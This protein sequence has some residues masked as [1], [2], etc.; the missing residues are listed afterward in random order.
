MYTP[1][2]G[3]TTGTNAYGYEAAVVGGKVTVA[4]DGV[5]NM[6]IPSNGYVLSGHGTSRTWLRTYAKVGATV[7]LDGTTTPLPGGTELLPDLAVRTLRNFEINTTAKPGVKQLK[8]PTVTAN[9]GKGPFEMNARRSSTSDTTWDMLQKIYRSDGTSTSRTVTGTDLYYGGDGHNHWHV[10]DVDQFEILNANGNRL[11][12]GEKHGFCFEDNTSYRDWPG[13]V[14]GSPASP[15]Y[16][17]PAIC[18]VGAT[19]ATSTQH[20]LS[21]GWGDTYPVTLP[22]QYIDITGLPNGRYRVQVTVDWDGWFRESNESNNTAWADISINN[23]TVS[24]VST[25]GGA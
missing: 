16:K 17:P 22:D 12:L 23:N 10:R 15:V 25:G 9:I 1:A 14:A 20:G 13:R 4:Q 3:A 19:Q 24:I 8:F 7:T 21:V 5:G 11:R 18:G 6:S 2:R